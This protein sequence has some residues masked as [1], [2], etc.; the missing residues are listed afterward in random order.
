M[1]AEAIARALGLLVLAA[2]AARPAA[3]GVCRSAN[4]RNLVLD[5]E[6]M[7][8]AEAF[9]T[10]IV[11]KH[12]LSIGSSF[13]DVSRQKQLYDAWIARGQT[14]NPAAKPGT[15]RHEA[16]FAFDI[17]GLQ[18]L[19]F[20]DWNNILNRGEKYGFTY[21][22]GD[23]PGEGNQKFD[24]PHFQADPL[25]Y[26]STFQQRLNANRADPAA[27]PRCA[28]TAAM[29]DE[30]SAY[31]SHL[32]VENVRVSN[33]HAKGQPLVYVDATIVNR[34]PLDVP[35][36]ELRLELDDSL[37]APEAIRIVRPVTAANPL[38]AGETRALHLRF[39]RIYDFLLDGPV[40]AAVT[41]VHLR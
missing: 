3:A 25:D 37:D 31:R 21:L 12:R 7:P 22:I 34:G 6:V 4:F 26:G 40:H 8:N 23:F 16:G 19:I 27:V 30:E 39:T 17:N 11:A 41:T 29:S 5:V 18:P 10:D 2:L 24:W 20:N 32:A 1:S 28:A 15:S 35:E 36:V 33:P 13:R 14:G 38:K 9:L